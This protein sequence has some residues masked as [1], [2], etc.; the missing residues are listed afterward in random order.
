MPSHIS[1]QTIYL[2]AFFQS[3]RNLAIRLNSLYS[4][5]RT[6]KKL[7]YNDGGKKKLTQCYTI[8]PQDLPFANNGIPHIYSVFLNKFSMCGLPFE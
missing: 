6:Y 2:Y 7:H 4:I 5:G 1:P 8:H 3:G